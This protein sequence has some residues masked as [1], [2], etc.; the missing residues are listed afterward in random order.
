MVSGLELDG[1]QLQLC[2]RGLVPEDGHPGH[3][4]LQSGSL[5]RPRHALK[6]DLAVGS[7]AVVSELSVSFK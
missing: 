4:V 2:P 5:A 7:L 3:G 6:C 1:M